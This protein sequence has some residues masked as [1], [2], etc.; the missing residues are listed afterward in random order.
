MTEIDEYVIVRNFI[1]RSEFCGSVKTV[2]M[3]MTANVKVLR[4][5]GALV[6]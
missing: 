6:S 5:E 4:R 3:N 1:G 2:K